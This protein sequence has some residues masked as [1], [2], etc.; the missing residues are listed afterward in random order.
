[1]G[2]HHAR[3]WPSAEHTIEFA[4]D[5]LQSYDRGR[6]RRRARDLLSRSRVILVPVVNVD[7]FKISRAPRR[8]VTSPPSTTR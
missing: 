4:F 6:R 1:M 2:A 5:L 8:S 3:E 7:G